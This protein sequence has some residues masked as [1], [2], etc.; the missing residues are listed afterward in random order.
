M[1]INKETMNEFDAQVREATG[2]WLRCNDLS[3]IQVNVGLKCNLQCVH[4]HVASSPK[5]KEEMNWQTMEQI[6]DV[7]ER[8]NCR[9]VDITGGAPEMNPN[10]RRLVEALARIGVPVMVRTN[11]TILLEPGYETLPS[12]LRDHHVQLVASL[13]CYLER[14]VDQQRG[15]GVYKGSVEAIRL[16]NEVGYGKDPA[17]PLSLVY[18]PV[19][20]HLPP[21]QFGLEEDYRRALS[22]R[23][24]IV[25]TNLLTIANMPIGRYVGALKKEGKLDEYQQL[26][27]RSFNPATIDGLMCRHQINVDWEGNIYDCDFNLALKMP[28]DHGAP[29]HISEFDSDVHARR[30]IVTGRHC[31]GCTAGAGSSCGGALT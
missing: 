8:I 23:F 28:V 20:P 31:F 30:R 25:F 12:F 2:D 6:I 14:N 21:N 4:C 9:L 3:T 18:N 13:P 1:V 16:L 22:D 10:F 17:L 24:G 5:R 7:A 11:L 19:G 29:T 26:L 15:D 27:R